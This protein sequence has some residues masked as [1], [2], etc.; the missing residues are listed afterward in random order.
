MI[1]KDMMVKNNNG[2]EFELEIYINV[3]SIMA[4]ERDL[5]QINPKY[6]YYNA[7]SLIDKGE[8]TITLIYVCNCVH[9]RGEKR[10]V[11]IDFF[12][13][14][15][16]NFFEYSKDLMQKLVECLLDNNPTVKQETGK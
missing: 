13:D 8:M 6:N 9:K 3:K 1:I 16:I 2:K 15:D 4:I 14:N 10:P 7:L 11:G 12:D 5:K